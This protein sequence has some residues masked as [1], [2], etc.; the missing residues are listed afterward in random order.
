VGSKILA[1]LRE[2][3]FTVEVAHIRAQVSEKELARL[4]PIALRHYGSE[5]IPPQ[6]GGPSLYG[7]ETNVLI[8]NNKE[9]ERLLASGTAT[10]RPD[11]RFDRKL[12]LSIAAGRA[13][14][15]L[16]DTIPF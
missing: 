3:G 13:L 2:R 15:E 5:D 8:F 1:E 7:G 12:G 11:E 14:K 6:W 16:N 10:C 4:R 9:R